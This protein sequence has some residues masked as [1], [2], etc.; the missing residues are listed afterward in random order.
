M[1]LERPGPGYLSNFGDFSAAAIVFLLSTLLA[2]APVHADRIS[3]GLQGECTVG[4][5]SPSVT[6]D[7]RPMLWKNRDVTDRDQRFIYYESY[8]RDGITTIPF[9][10]NVYRNDTTGVYM[11]ANLAGFAIMNSDSYNLGDSLSQI[12]ITDGTLMRLALETCRTLDDF[13]SLL[14]STGGIG[15]RDCW[16]FGVFDFSGDCAIYEC[17]NFSYVKVTADDSD[18]HHGGFMIRANYSFTGSDIH[19]GEDRYERARYLVNSRLRDND[20]DPEFVLGVMSRDLYNIYDDPYPLPYGNTQRN[21]PPGYIYQIGTISGKW[22]T[23]AVVLRGCAPGED[24]ALATIFA[25]LGSPIISVAYPLWVKSGTVPE[26]LSDPDGAAML[27]ICQSRAAR[28]YDIEVLPYH[29]NSAALLDDLGRG[30]YSY[31]LPIEKWG[32]DC[33]DR[34]LS[35]WRDEPPAA[36]DVALEQDRI[37]DVIFNNFALETFEYLPESEFESN[38]GPGKITLS[39]FPNPFNGSTTIVVDGLKTEFP[40]TVRIYDLLGR[41]VRKLN[42]TLP[43]SNSVIWDGMDTNGDVVGSGIY[44]YIV[45][46]GRNIGS[47]R[48]VVLK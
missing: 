26:C 38:T 27:A 30:I 35:A 9:I 15:R 11:G 39:N 25:V 37:S 17:S 3:P 34:L 5:F 40:L 36:F 14:D 22:T 12:G 31:T 24:P 4:V 45:E 19:T 18:N 7:G 42:G 13:E 33:A 44:Y 23:S 48:V 28:I 41:I 2:V 10:G 43:G 21:G 1:N 16:N 20:I 32:I 29:L 46:D 8:R 47:N 6:S